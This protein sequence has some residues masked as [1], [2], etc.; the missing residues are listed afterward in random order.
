MRTK[1]VSFRIGKVQGFLRG[2]VW[3]LCYHEHGRRR[4]PRVGPDRQG[5]KRLAAQINAQ[6]LVGAPAA[7]SFEPVAIPALR[8][9]W[10]SHHEQVLRSSVQTINRY[11]TA[12][13]HLL[14]FLDQRPV[15]HASHFHT[16]HAEEFVR[17]LRALE[18]SPNGHKNT[19]KRPLMDKGLRYVLECCRALFNFAAKHRHL[20]PYAENPFRVLE[21]DRIPVEQSRPIDL[22]TRDQEKAFLET[23]DDW[24]FPIFLTLLLT[25]LRPG[26]LCHLLLPHDLDLE[27][28]WLRV[29]NK[30][31]LGWQ[32]KTRNER[33]IP[34]LPVLLDVL[35]ISLNGRT[36]GPVFRRRSWSHDRRPAFDASSVQALES[37]MRQRIEKHDAEGVETSR[38]LRLGLA[39][40]VWRDLGAIKG[41]R[42]RVEFMR[43]TRS[44]GIPACTA[45]K[46]LRHQFA[47]ALQE[48]RV[49][50]LIRNLLMGHAAT[51][52]KTPGHG[53]GMTA[54]YTH[55]RPE[56]C[57][58]QLEEA[59]GN[60]AAADAAAAWVAQRIK[61]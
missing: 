1:S 2:K 57:R 3:Y 54:V 13:E 35:R 39:K 28:G 17:Y 33:D 40:G 25:G 24:Q 61:G 31:R 20:S 4:R 37:E 5:A 10:L 19:V 59:L 60:R 58:M 41:D 45:P 7:L 11:R 26:E 53:L 32:V 46:L 18:V 16:H 55:S 29:R 12:T 52:E 51:G 9:R 8:D 36:T 27:S 56:T 47:T 14:R 50:P 38:A 21:I 30:P 43:L 23:C 15:R 22:F 34:L 44:I 48:G 42:I 49:D 6:L